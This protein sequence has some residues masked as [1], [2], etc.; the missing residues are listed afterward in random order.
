MQGHREMD[1]AH[2]NCEVCLLELRWLE[3]VKWIPER[4]CKAMEYGK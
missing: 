3:S 1:G 4:D 2:R